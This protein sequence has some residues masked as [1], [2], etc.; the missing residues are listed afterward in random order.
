MLKDSPDWSSVGDVR[1]SRVVELQ[2]SPQLCADT[3]TY[4]AAL[5]VAPR[6]PRMMWHGLP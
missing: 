1:G 3:T 6:A 5:A 4:V 2:R